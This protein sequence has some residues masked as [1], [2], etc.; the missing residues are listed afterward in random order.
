VK[1]CNNQNLLD[2]YALEPDQDF[3]YKLE[4]THHLQTCPLCRH[5]V[6]ERRI[7]ETLFSSIPDTKDEIIIKKIQQ[8]T[9]LL[10]TQVIVKLNPQSRKSGNKHDVRLAADDTSPIQYTVLET[11]SNEKEDVVVRLIKEHHKTACLYLI[12]NDKKRFKDALLTFEGSDH[13]YIFNEQNQVIL[14]NENVEELLLRKASIRTPVSKFSL[15]PQSLK[16]GNTLYDGPIA[17]TN[18]HLEEIQIEVSNQEGKPT[19][20]LQIV[21]LNVPFKNQKMHVAIFQK[22][23]PPAISL[24]KEGSA[25]FKKI[26]PTNILKI[27]F[28]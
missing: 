20:T 28:Y 22:N 4:L 19:Y 3:K 1:F 21:N 9:G 8:M 16:S 14:V 24:V 2:R 12:C 17:F 18:D 7:L 11:Y 6:K 10:K 26:N 5:Y 15:H 27:H 13:R 23:K 25:V